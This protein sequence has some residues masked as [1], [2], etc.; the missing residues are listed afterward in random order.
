MCKRLIP[1]KR[2]KMLRYTFNPVS[3]GAHLCLEFWISSDVL[4]TL[5]RVFGDQKGNDQ[6]LYYFN[7]TRVSEAVQN[8]QK[9]SRIDMKMRP[10]TEGVKRIGCVTE[11]G[12]RRKVGSR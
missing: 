8:R 7:P 1:Q 3:T 5:G 6:N 12:G 10:N 11:P 9:I 4:L 2:R